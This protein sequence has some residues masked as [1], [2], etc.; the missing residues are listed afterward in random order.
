MRHGDLPAACLYTWAWSGPGGGDFAGLQDLLEHG[1]AG[2]MLV[3]GACPRRTGV[4]AANQGHD[5]ES[6]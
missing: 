2:A 6:Q 3:F 1:T 5:G 4:Y